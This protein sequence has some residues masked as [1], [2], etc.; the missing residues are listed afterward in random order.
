M[1]IVIWIAGLAGILL[2]V[3]IWIVVLQK[4]YGAFRISPAKIVEVNPFKDEKK[5][6]MYH[7]VVEIF[8]AE[9]KKMMYEF[10]VA[11][12][13]KYAVGT[14]VKAAISLKDNSRVE[15]W[16]FWKFYKAPILFAISAIIVMATA[17][18][19]LK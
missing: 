16:S 13:D 11:D 15:L 10:N 8:N 7:A 19:I 5:R 6:Q 17:F 9:N 14:V 12:K 2:F 4:S 3:L 18:I 1:S